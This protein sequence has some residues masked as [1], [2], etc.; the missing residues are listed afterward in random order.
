MV[1]SSAL[2]WIV[3]NFIL[4]PFGLT[5][6]TTAVFVLLIA[7]FVQLLEMVIKKYSPALYN[8]WGIYLLL[9]ATNCIVLSV[10]LLNV[11][12]SY[13]FLYSLVNAVGSGL[14]FALAIVLMASCR[15]KLR[16]ADVPKPLEGIGI[17][18]IIAGMLALSFLGFS[19]MIG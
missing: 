11:E 14:G 17:A 18:F 9:I 3:Y 8:M 1:M 12:S 10:P 5:F 6:M 19:G 13:G 16:L 4:L 15:E 2:A 7:S